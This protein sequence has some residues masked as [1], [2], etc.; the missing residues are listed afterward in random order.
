MQIIVSKRLHYAGGERRPKIEKRMRNAEHSGDFCSAAM[1]G[2]DARTAV[3]FPH[4]KRHS[5]NV[6]ALLDQQTRRH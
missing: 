3:F 4:A 1:I 2:T 5:V 6:I